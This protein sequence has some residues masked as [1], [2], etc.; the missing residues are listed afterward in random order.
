MCAW[1]DANFGSNKF[2]ILIWAVIRI[3]IT[4]I[5]YLIDFHVILVTYGRDFNVSY[6]SIN[7]SR[8]DVLCSQSSLTLTP[9]I[10]L[11]MMIFLSITSLL[12]IIYD[13]WDLSKRCFIWNQEMKYLDKTP[14]GSKC[15]ILH[16]IFYCITHFVAHVSLFAMLISIW[17]VIF[18]GSHFLG[19]YIYFLVCIASVGNVWGLFYFIQ[20]LPSIGYFVI[21][22]QRMIKDLIQL[23][24]I[25][26]LFHL[27]FV[28]AF[29]KILD[30]SLKWCFTYDNVTKVYIKDE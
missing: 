26:C 16:L 2:D 7:R 21:S 30:V 14:R 6:L 13:I 5:F 1:L 23:I 3:N 19:S 12:I 20:I 17:M 8:T 11:I 15:F 10:H 25:F 4:L 29:I 22:I 18:Y 28:Y 24:F 9:N 27:S